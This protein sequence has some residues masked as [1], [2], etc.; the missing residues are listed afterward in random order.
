MEP[1][2]GLT[3]L[4]AA[5]GS[6]NVVEKILG[7]TAEYVGSGLKDWTQRSVRNVGRIFEHAR[8]LLGYKIDSP[9]AV[10]PRVLKE[11]LKEGPFC[12]DQLWA[13][14]FGGVLA[15]SRTENGRDDR[16][17]RFAAMISR[18]STYQVRLHFVIYKLVKLLFDGT[19]HSVTTPAARSAL[20]TFIPFGTFAA[21]MEL[22]PK[23]Q[24]DVILQHAVV[25]LVTEG[26]IE[27]RCQFG[28][29]EH[30]Q[31]HGFKEADTG[32]ILV[33]PSAL[34][35]ELFHWAHGLGDLHPVRFLKSDTH[36]KSQV[37]LVITPGVRSVRDPSRI[38]DEV[39]RTKSGDNQEGAG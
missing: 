1:G 37:R 19:D 12:E 39:L 21:A 22:G 30:I 25:G 35:V 7:P 32:G 6:A 10:P 29:T 17:A 24:P 33:E 13:E 15:S 14:Y 2:T 16:G 20:T 34:G 31:S 4:G 23:E 8:V 3:V 27:Q 36:F 9:G 38:L 11:V 5:L 28:P 26:L 18:L